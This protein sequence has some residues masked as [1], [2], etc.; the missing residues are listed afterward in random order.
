MI[1]V[2]TD[3]Q[4]LLLIT[5]H[6]GIHVGTY[7]GRKIVKRVSFLCISESMSILSNDRIIRDKK[8][9][10]KQGT[11]VYWLPVKE[12]ITSFGQ[13][14][15]LINEDTKRHFSRRESARI[16]VRLQR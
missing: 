1:P 5:E 12:E 13:A 10:L 7:C 2:G 14:R 3:G 8:R 16:L 15:S 4:K 6:G 9:L 11:I